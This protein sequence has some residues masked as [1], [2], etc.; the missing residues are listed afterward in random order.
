MPS[1]TLGSFDFLGKI[2]VHFS[3]KLLRFQEFDKIKKDQKLSLQVLP[4]DE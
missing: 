2:N 1:I 3:D 4:F